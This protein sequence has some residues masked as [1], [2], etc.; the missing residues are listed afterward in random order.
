M[1]ILTSVSKSTQVLREFF[2]WSTT[3]KITVWALGGLSNGTV[4]PMPDEIGIT[5]R[6]IFLNTQDL[7]EIFSKKCSFRDNDNTRGL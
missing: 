3:P 1:P 2:A 5:R 4:L 7:N 6:A